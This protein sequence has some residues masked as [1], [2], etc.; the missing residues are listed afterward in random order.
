M[1]DRRLPLVRGDIWFADLDPVRG[2]E[3]AGT[4]PVLIISSDRYQRAQNRLVVVLAM[5]SKIRSYPFHLEVQPE[6]TGLAKVGAIMCDQVRIIST[7]RLI[8]SK[9]AGRVVENTLDRVEVLIHRLF[10][11]T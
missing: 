1:V 9:P 7:E 4:R 3:Q 6:E 2:S 11:L 5:T 8:G 10:E